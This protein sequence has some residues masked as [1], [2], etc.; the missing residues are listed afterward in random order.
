MASAG[1]IVLALCAAAG[2]TPCAARK[3][4]RRSRVST[5][6]NALT[7]VAEGWRLAYKRTTG[8]APKFAGIR[9]T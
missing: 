1:A 2:D 9:I 5:S 8:L 6:C 3:R 4:V 7:N